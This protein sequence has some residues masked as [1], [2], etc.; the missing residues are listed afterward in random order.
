MKFGRA[1]IGP[2][3]VDVGSTRIK[4]VQLRHLPGGPELVRSASIPRLPSDGAFGPAEASRLAGV[5][6]RQGFAGDRVVAC[7]PP[8]KLLSG[9]MELPP[10]SS[11]APLDQIAR[12][13]LA[14]ATKCDPAQ[15]EVSWWV[16]PGGVRAAEGTHAM[17]VGCRHEDALALMDA[18]SAAGLDV[19][20]IDAPATA[21]AAAVAPMSGSAG[22]LSSV[23]EIGHSSSILIMLLGR[24]VVYERVL[25]ECGAGRLIDGLAARLGIDGADAEVLLRSVGCG[26]AQQSDETHLARRSTDEEDMNA[27]VRSAASAFTDTLIGELRLS[28]A[29]AMRR[30]DVQIARVLMAGAA[31]AM[32]G[33]VQRV[34]EQLEVECRAPG[35]RE[36]CSVVAQDGLEP[37]GPEGM[38]ALGLALHSGSEGGHT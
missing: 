31:A 6:R 10:M 1:K 26:N 19:L 36:A 8:G 9:V 3:G 4:A 38:L 30:F 29:Y 35:L 22:E 32:P 7:I 17:A 15:I 18:M 12:Q 13:E 27:E 33:L 34:G 24:M 5:L 25:A 20:A 23:V 16:L 11:G 21:L 28:A 37:L 2:I 14:R